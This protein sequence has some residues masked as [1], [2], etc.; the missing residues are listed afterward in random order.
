[1]TSD[2]FIALCP[3]ILLHSI[4]FE[5]QIQ[6]YFFIRIGKKVEEEAIAAKHSVAVSVAF[7]RNVEREFFSFPERTR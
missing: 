4:S 5:N 7:L 1:M 2:I 6:L 3:A